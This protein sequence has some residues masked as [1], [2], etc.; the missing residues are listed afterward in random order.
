MIYLIFKVLITI[1]LVSTVI[2]PVSLLSIIDKID[3]DDIKGS[4]N[5]M[6]KTFRGKFFIYTIEFFGR[7]SLISIFSMFPLFIV[8]L[9]QKLWF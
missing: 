6:D 5:K 3:L 2:I 8:W 4:F 7:L 9:V 1:I